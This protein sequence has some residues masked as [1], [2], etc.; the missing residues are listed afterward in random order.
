VQ[1]EWDAAKAVSNRRK[2]G[3][4]FAEAQTVFDDPRVIVA[5]DDSHSAREDRWAVIGVSDRGRVLVVTYTPRRHV[6]RIVTARK[7]TRKEI[8]EYVQG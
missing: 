7:A 5:Y 6:P 2:H 4:W 8:D 1:C 3:I